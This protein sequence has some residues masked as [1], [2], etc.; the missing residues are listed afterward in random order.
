MGNHRKRN[1]ISTLSPFAF[2]NVI[3]APSAHNSYAGASFPGLVDTLFEIEKTTGE[4]KD[5]RWKDVALQLS[6][7]TFFIENA[8]S[9]LQPPVD[10]QTLCC[11]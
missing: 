8:A 6:A 4:E 7:V 10:F 2:R 3:F 11:Q 1:C 5:K 9:S